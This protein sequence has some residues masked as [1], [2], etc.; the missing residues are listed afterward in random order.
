MWGRSQSAVT[1]IVSS[2]PS[3]LNLLIW[4]KWQKKKTDLIHPHQKIMNYNF[5]KNVFIQEIDP[6][7]TNQIIQATQY[8]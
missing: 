5:F 1:E 6:P 4:Y 7:V 8:L 2:N 3:R